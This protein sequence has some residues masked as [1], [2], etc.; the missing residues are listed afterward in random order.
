M[1][2]WA[3]AKRRGGKPGVV[4][5]PGPP[6]TPE[7]EVSGGHLWQ[8][9]T[10]GDDTGGTVRLMRAA[11]ENGGYSQHATSAW[12]AAKDWGTTA[13]LAGFWYRCQEI[14]NGTSYG[15]QSALTPPLHIT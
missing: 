10:G 7:A 8:N 15:G 2:R 9:A 3:Q 14:G 12:A 4:Q 13:S 6:L 1:G 5:G 11:T